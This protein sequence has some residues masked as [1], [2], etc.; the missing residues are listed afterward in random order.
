MASEFERKEQSGRAGWRGMQ[1][2]KSASFLP[3]FSL[4]TPDTSGQLS[5][6]LKAGD[7]ADWESFSFPA[8]LQFS[9]ESV[10]PAPWPAE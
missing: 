2:G 5:E 9:T 3:V 8:E 7:M 6:L 10:L 1:S 4:S